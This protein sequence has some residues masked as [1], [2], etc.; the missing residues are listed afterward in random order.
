MRIHWRRWIGR[1]GDREEHDSPQITQMNADKILTWYLQERT[2]QERIWLL[3][4]GFDLDLLHQFL[5][6]DGVVAMTVG[7]GGHHAKLLGLVLPSFGTRFLICV[8]LELVLVLAL[9]RF[10]FGL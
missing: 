10:W 8:A 6:G 2:L 9:E 5:V 4:C 7:P 1:G 3:I